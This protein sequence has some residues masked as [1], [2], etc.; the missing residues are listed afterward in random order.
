MMLTVNY[1][2]GGTSNSMAS[3]KQQVDRM[4]SNH[5]R[6]LAEAKLSAPPQAGF[7][8]I[9][10]VYDPAK[11]QEMTVAADTFDDM[12]LE[13]K[14]I[15]RYLR[16]RGKHCAYFPLASCEDFRTALDDVRISDIVV[17][18][19]AQLSRMHI[20]PWVRESAP[21]K[22]HAMLN[23]YDVISRDGK[24]P[25]ISHLKQG[26]FYQRTSG[27][28]DKAHLNI[29]FAWGFM[30]D[31]AKIWALPQMGFYPNHRHVRP[32]AGLVNIARHFGLRQVDLYRMSYTRAIDV[33]GMRESV[34]PRRYAIPQFAHPAYDQLRANRRLHALHDAIRGSNHAIAFDE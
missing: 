12:N 29:P 10:T 22:W 6:L 23:F 16:W 21:D 33:F 34:L 13:A 1:V 30:A 7:T 11:L 28:M 9:L 31:R 32:Q 17:I 26:S 19:L 24:W 20:T 5:E 25:T 4:E 15:Q 14:R 8:A 3:D 27:R 18:G 2:P